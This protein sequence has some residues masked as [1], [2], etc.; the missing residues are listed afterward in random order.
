MNRTEVLSGR[1]G[2]RLDLLLSSS[3]LDITRSRAQR[4]IEQGRVRVDGVARTRPS[5]R[6]VGGERVEVEIPEP[7]PPALQPE[8]IPLSILYEDSDVMVVDKPAGMVVHPAPGHP[9]STLVHAALAHAPDLE[10]IGGE[11]RP[12]IVHRL[13]RGTSGVIVIAKNDAAFR[14][15]QA[16]F[17]GRTV[18]K[19]YRALVIGLPT[20]PAGEITGAIGRHP[21][22]RKRMAVVGKGR[23][24]ESVTRFRIL[25]RYPEHAELEVRPET[26]RT[27]QIRV[28]LASI[29]CPVLG[30]RVYA[31]RPS[32]VSAPR[33]M[34][35]AWRIR[36]VLPGES[37]PRL[38]EA[39][40]P[41]DY[42]ET[43]EQLRAR[44]GEARPLHPGRLGRGARR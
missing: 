30:D 12:G 6:L 38:L 2:E 26:G 39:P 14:A 17:Q 19:V 3:S 5:H 28:H 43:R 22:D 44:T 7:G 34:L 24:R 41:S 32:S 21:R 11:R 25:E 10:G 16:Q 15:L 8:P 29:G 31:H 42:L 27:H 33:P 37:D 23:G 36:L 20:A 35:H 18:E 4:W 1:S 9:A 13:D 40:L